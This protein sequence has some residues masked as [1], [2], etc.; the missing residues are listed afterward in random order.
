MKALGNTILRASAGTG[1]TFRLSSRY[2]QLLRLRVEPQTI[3]AT[4]FT[5]KAAGEILERILKRL[6]AAAA[7]ESA[8]G[9]LGKELA[10]GALNREAARATL[11]DLCGQ[12]HHL[13]ISTIDAFFNRMAQSFRNEL[14]IPPRPRIIGADDPLAAQ[15]RA[16]AIDDLLTEGL[17]GDPQVL[18]D[19]LRRLHH[20]AAQRSVHQAIDAIVA[21]LYDVYRQAPEA[22]IW[23]RL[24]ETPGTLDASGI[25]AAVEVL[26]RLASVLPADKRFARA[27]QA[28]CQTAMARDWDGFL[29]AGLTAGILKDGRFSGKP[30][31]EPLV[32]AYRPLIAHAQSYLVG[33]VARRAQAL[34]DLLQ[35]FDRHYTKLRLQQRILLFGDLPQKLARD[36]PRRP[37]LAGEVYYRLDTRVAH[38]L[39]DEFQDTSVEQWSVLRPFVEEIISH[40]DPQQAGRSFF[41]VGDEKQAIY[42]WR[43][44]CREIFD[45]VEAELAHG[46]F[47]TEQMQTSYRSSQTV[48]DAVNALFGHLADNPVLAD[49]A[50]Q[51]AHT[52][53]EG[54][55]KHIANNPNLAG[56]VELMTAPAAPERDDD[57]EDAD[58]VDSATAPVEAVSAYEQFIAQ[59]VDAIARAAPG[60]TIGILTATNGCVRRL[61]FALRRLG[62]NASGEGG[63][64]LTDDPAVNAVLAAL[65]LADHPGDTIASFHVVTSPLGAVLGL[66][67][68]RAD[69]VQRVVAGIRRSLLSEGYARTLVRWARALALSCSARSVQRLGQLVELADRYEPDLSL[70][71]GRFVEFVQ[72]TAVEEPAPA[73]IRVM[74]V[75]K[76]KGL[77][78]DA[79]VLAELDRRW[80]RLDR[81]PVYVYRQSP[82]DPIS[83]VYA[84][85]RKEIRDLDPQLQ[86]AYAQ[87]FARRMQDDLCA[88]Y[89]GMTRPRYA[90]Y[91]II[92][93]LKPK[94]DGKP[95][96]RGLTDLSP[97]SILRQALRPVDFLETF[98]G[99][100]VLYSAGCAGWAELLEAAAP[101]VPTPLQ[102][103]QLT[104]AA[105]P[106][107]RRGARAL[108]PSHL[109][110]GGYV[111]PADLL[112][113][114]TPVGRATGTLL[115]AWFSTIAWLDDPAAIPD[116]PALLHLAV[117]GRLASADQ[118]RGLLPVFR[119]MLSQPRIIEALSRRRFTHQATEAPLD[120]DLWRERRFVVRVADDLIQGVFD[121]VVIQRRAG[122]IVAAEI[123]DYKTDHLDGPEATALQEAVARY[124]PQMLAY[125][126]ALASMLNLGPAA[127]TA[128][129]LFTGLPRLV[130]ISG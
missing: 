1:K 104:L 17:A 126:A 57:E 64:P 33:R 19:L 112:A 49:K 83:A 62:M 41:C 18:I 79:V 51:E 85:A 52:W 26:G 120:L 59:R 77:E 15:L 58:A 84:S 14:G 86:A 9:K 53:Q 81:L 22:E 24:S 44:G 108:S 56:C 21:G 28:N 80:G 88:L 66:V 103:I 105:A 96:A 31:P 89:V 91:M 78:F 37:D 36:L 99:N 30:I 82:T 46:L 67:S 35:R 127:I 32:E 27:F 11:A 65:T 111:Q 106:Q 10:D 87:E 42:A 45:L 115:H 55:A 116:D 110:A 5:R 60:R 70:R 107:A 121:R 7:D 92:P 50:P 119:R 124:R 20:D 101:P 130:P 23:S 29:K 6:A 98:A 4:T 123:L 48:L 69:E 114:T 2:L 100:E 74:T 68:T 95:G 75:H 8:A 12:L 39:L 47:D 129:L 71:P 38:L 109:E 72:G 43:G 125:R 93:A 61:I 3:L 118:A 16:L 40:G 122:R 94:G 54:F 63:G 113:L 73:L 117:S 25:S 13:S 102:P 97:A 128:H 90:L 34:H 76:A